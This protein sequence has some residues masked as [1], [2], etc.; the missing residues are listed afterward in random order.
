MLLVS[1]ISNLV[2][3][4]V[5]QLFTHWILCVY[6]VDTEVRCHNDQCGDRHLVLKIHPGKDREDLQRDNLR[7]C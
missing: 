6:L 4:I 7:P 5:T 1:D 3:S 2:L